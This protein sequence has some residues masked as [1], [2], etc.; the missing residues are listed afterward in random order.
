VDYIERLVSLI[1]YEASYFSDTY[2]DMLSRPVLQF[3][4]QQLGNPLK[5]IHTTVSNAIMNAFA[6]GNSNLVP[7]IL[8]EI[9]SFLE[10]IN[11]K[12]FEDPDETTYTLYPIIAIL[13]FFFDKLVKEIGKD[14]QFSNEELNNIVILLTN[15]Y[16]EKVIDIPK[17]VFSKFLE[18]AEK[19]INTRAR[20]FTILIRQSKI[21][22]LGPTYEIQRD[23]ILELITRLI[24]KDLATFI[25]KHNDK[26]TEFVTLIHDTFIDELMNEGVLGMDGASNLENIFFWDYYTEEVT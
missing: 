13:D 9:G 15:A 12:M 20:V 11:K 2:E 1:I 5:S 19:D 8:D 24:K 22:K 18:M 10:K 4:V 6:I 17:S 7:A 23:N 16:V 26:V 14:N 3:M 25:V 21:N